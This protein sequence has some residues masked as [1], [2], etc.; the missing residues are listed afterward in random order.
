[1]SSRF[2]YFSPSLLVTKEKTTSQRTLHGAVKPLK[3]IVRE[4]GKATNDGRE[5]ET[6][7]NRLAILSQ[8]C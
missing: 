3:L 5:S 2:S 1:M 8:P 4:L 7:G 6:E